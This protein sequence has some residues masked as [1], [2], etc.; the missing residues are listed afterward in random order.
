MSGYTVCLSI[1]PKDVMKLNSHSFRL[2]GL[3]ETESNKLAASY[4]VGK[5]M[6]MG[7]I[8]EDDADSGKLATEG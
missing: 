4:E 6:W 2:F 8:V 3:D 1:F 7:E 5:K